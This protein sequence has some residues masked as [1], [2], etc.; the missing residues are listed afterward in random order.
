[1][2]VSCCW[3]LVRNNISVCKSHSKDGFAL[4]LFNDVVLCYFFILQPNKVLRA[5]CSFSRTK[6][7]LRKAS[8]RFEL[9][10][11]RQLFGSVFTLFLHIFPRV[12]VLFC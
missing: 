11:A 9:H 1:M 6:K 10:S 5:D 4:K 2:A 12:N 8:P 3:V 7:Q